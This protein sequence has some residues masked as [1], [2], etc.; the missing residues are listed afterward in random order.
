MR[1]N[2]ASEEKVIVNGE[3]LEDVDTLSTWGPRLVQLAEQMMT[4]LPDFVKQEQCLVNCQ[5]SGKAAS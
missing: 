3:E 5:V 1:L 4:S 2:D